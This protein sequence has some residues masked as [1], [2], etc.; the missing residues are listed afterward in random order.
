MAASEGLANIRFQDLQP[1]MM[2]EDLL[3]LATIHLL[4]QIAEAADL[5]LPSKLTNMLSSGR[6]VLATASP[7]TGLSSEVEGCGVLCPP[8]DASTMAA[9][10]AMLL[11]DG[12]ACMRYG[13]AARKR[14]EERWS[15]LAILSKFSTALEGA[16]NRPGFPGGYLV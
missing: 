10:L 11:D 9:A 8:G 3:G 6:P 14:A 16:V 5:V 2:M 4:P 15:K 13:V 7:D 1:M 12:A